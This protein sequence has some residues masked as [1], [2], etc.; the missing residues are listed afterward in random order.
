MKI[1]EHHLSKLKG[2][3]YHEDETPEAEVEPISVGQ[4]GVRLPL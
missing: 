1:E 2:G 3:N 4:T